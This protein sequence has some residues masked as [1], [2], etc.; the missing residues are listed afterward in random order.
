[1]NT[2]A[3]NGNLKFSV[4]NAERFG[5]NYNEPDF[6]KKLKSLAGKAGRKVAYNALLLYYVLTS[7]D[8]PVRYKGIIIGALGY[9]ILPIDLI[10]DF[11]PVAGFTDDLA[12]LVAVV[13]MVSDCVDSEIERKAKEKV[14]ELF[15]KE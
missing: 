8:V 1:M 13:K 10:P 6:W 7:R 5:G 12:A 4:D 9:L 3:D 14:E 2:N 15:G 11:I